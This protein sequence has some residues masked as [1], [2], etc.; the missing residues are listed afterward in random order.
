M[1]RLLVVSGLVLSV[2]AMFAV[3]GAAKAAPAPSFVAVGSLYLVQF[4]DGGRS[5]SNLAQENGIYVKVTN[6][7][8]GG[9]ITGEWAERIRNGRDGKELFPYGPHA[10]QNFNLNVACAVSIPLK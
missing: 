8:E 7:F 6:I 5:I 10:A 2:V 9:W 4:C 1:K 3:R